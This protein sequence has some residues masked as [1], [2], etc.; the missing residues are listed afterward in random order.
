MQVQ[1]YTSDGELG[2]FLDALLVR[3][4]FKN[5][6]GGMPVGNGRVKCMQVGFQIMELRI[7]FHLAMKLQNQRLMSSRVS[8]NYVQDMLK[9][10]VR[11]K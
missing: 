1:G 8:K 11:N 7:Y 10:T 5:K 6:D 3:A 9:K 4:M 2:S